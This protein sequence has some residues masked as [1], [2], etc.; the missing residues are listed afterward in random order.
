MMYDYWYNGPFLE[1]LN[2]I[3]ITQHQ[4]FFKVMSIFTCATAHG[5]KCCQFK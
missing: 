4:H 5:S 2:N 1:N 3:L